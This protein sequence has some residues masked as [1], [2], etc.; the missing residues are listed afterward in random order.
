MEGVKRPL[1][2]KGYICGGG[3]PFSG[4][5]RL[6]PPLLKCPPPTLILE[7]NLQLEII[8]PCPSPPIPLCASLS[9]LCKIVR[10]WRYSDVANTIL[11]R[12][13]AKSRKPN[14]MG[15]GCQICANQALT[16]LIYIILYYIQPLGVDFLIKF[17]VKKIC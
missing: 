12:G 7:C 10:N 13:V 6:V 17:V 3:G 1:C 11:G 4:L 14:S 16:K 8:H 5:D 2:S 9:I 15:E